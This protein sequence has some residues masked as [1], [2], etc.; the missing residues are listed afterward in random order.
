[1]KVSIGK[2]PD[3]FGP[4]HIADVIFFWLEKWPD[5]KLL[6]R[7][8]YRLHD[9]FAEWLTS[10]WVNDLCQWIYDKNKRKIKIQIDPYDT[11]S[12][13]HTLSLIIVPMLKRLKETKHGY[14]ITDKEDT[15][16]IPAD[17]DAY[18][19]RWD[20]IMDE[21]IWTHEQIIDECEDKNYYVPYGPDETPKM[22][23]FMG[24]Y[25]TKEIVIGWGKFDQEK[26][27][28]YYARVQNGLR[29]FGKYYRSLWD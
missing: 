16:H 10:T 24:E 26:H 27:D 1:M 25:L 2:Y 7:W 4:Y 22:P 29:L 13:D 8:D 17:D 19:K 11:W 3:W 18:E 12:M 9:K 23:E 6:D 20:W 5:E 15:P 14:P 28:A 21:I